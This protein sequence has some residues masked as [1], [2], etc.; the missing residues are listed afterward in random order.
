MRN[1]VLAMMVVGVV[2]LQAS[3]VYIENTSTETVVFYDNFDDW[4]AFLRKKLID[5]LKS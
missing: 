2:A 4:V 5:K 3:A 1:A